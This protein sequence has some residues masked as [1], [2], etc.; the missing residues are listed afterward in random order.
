MRFIIFMVCF[1]SIIFFSSS[2]HESYHAIFSNIISLAFVLGGTL[3]AT[4]ISFPIEKIKQVSNVLK[5]AYEIEKFDYSETTKYTLHLVR[6]YKKFGFKSLESASKEITNP[7][8]RLG[9]QMIAD[10]SEWKLIKTAIEK[11]Y[12]YDTTQNESSQR[13]LRSMSKYAP[14]FGLAGTIIG[15]MKVF[16]QLTNPVNI[17]SAISIALLTTLY[18]VLASNLIFMPL[19]NKLKENSTDEEIVLRFNLEALRC[20]YDKDYTII[21]EQR[22]A[23]LMPK[24]E[25]S[26]YQSEKSEPLQ[27]RLSENS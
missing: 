3:I 1:V 21:I 20:I 10:R 25:Y 18:G 15:L 17:G 26:K 5:K 6:E 27:L 13:I 19:A 16:P 9:Y 4:M 12:I 23:G 2:L 8:L 11:E 14:S 22:L 7:Y 24:H